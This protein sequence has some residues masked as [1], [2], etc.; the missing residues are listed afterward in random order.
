MRRHGQRGIDAFPF[1]QDG[2]GTSLLAGCVPFFSQHR[3]AEVGPWHSLEHL[4]HRHRMALLVNSY[5]AS[6]GSRT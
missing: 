6:A 1:R 4:W 5:P 3:G 2:A